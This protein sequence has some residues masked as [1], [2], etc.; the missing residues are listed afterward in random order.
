M[1][2]MVAVR[3]GREVAQRMMRDLCDRSFQPLREAQAAVAASILRTVR[4]S[5]SGLTRLTMY[6]TVSPSDCDHSVPGRLV[7]TR[8]RARRP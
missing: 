5:A 2:Y 8:S 3:V 6:L 4:A 1:T 7:S